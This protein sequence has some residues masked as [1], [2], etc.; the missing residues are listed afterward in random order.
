MAKLGCVKLL[1][2]ITMLYVG[3]AH[4]Q[5]S[6]A[7]AEGNTIYWAKPGFEP[8]YIV[9]G[10]YRNRGFGDLTIVQLAKLL[11][12]YRHEV[13][14]ANYIRLMS[15]LNRG[16]NVCG[17]LHKTPEREQFIHYSNALILAPSY[18]LYSSVSAQDKF[19]NHPGWREGKIS[20]NELL[21]NSD[22]LRMAQTPGHS[23]GKARD[24]II[25]RHYDKLIITKGYAGQKSLI[26][27]LL[28]DRVDLILEFPWV[29]N[30]HLYQ[31]KIDSS[32]VH[33]VNLTDVPAYEPAYIACPKNPWGKQVVMALNNLDPPLYRQVDTFIEQWLE[34]AEI[35]NFR[36]ANREYFGDD[37]LLER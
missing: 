36:Q 18:Q 8:M 32:Q 23:Y 9:S 7:S 21:A 2:L 14:R 1:L 12:Q 33:K 16:N 11:P 31:F 17:I 29:F 13:M 24:D 30:H 15:Q 27:M 35:E 10:V 4:A 25:L 6:Q 3:T 5:Q 37:W 28:A 19:Q 20:F 26:K 22:R 34:P